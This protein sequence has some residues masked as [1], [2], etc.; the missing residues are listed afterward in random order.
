MPS[1]QRGL[2]DMK[3]RQSKRNAAKAMAKRGKS[4]GRSLFDRC[5]VLLPDRAR[6]QCRRPGHSPVHELCRCGADNSRAFEASA[7][8]GGGAID[9]AR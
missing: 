8:Q 7:A 5:R 9:G 4:D 2:I 3:N 6:R 1:E